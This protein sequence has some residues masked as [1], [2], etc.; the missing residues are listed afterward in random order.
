[1]VY[2]PPP[3]EENANGGKL[4]EDIFFVNVSSNDVR[5]CY[6]I[7]GSDT[8]R[9]F[10]RSQGT[11]W[12][13]VAIFE[14]GVASYF[15]ARAPP[16]PKPVS[17]DLVDEQGTQ[18]LDYYMK[19]GSHLFA[20]LQGDT[21]APLLLK[22]ALSDTS[23]SSMAVLRAILALS[24][25]HLHRTA[26]ALAY[27]ASAISLLSTSIKA[28]SET[29]VAF[30]TS[31]A[32]MLL[33]MFEVYHVS[34]TSL[35]WAVYLC[36]VKKIILDALTQRVV[37]DREC[38]TLRDW[39]YFY[40]VLSRFSILHW[41]V[42]PGRPR[43]CYER[44]KSELIRIAPDESLMEDICAVGYSRQVFDCILTITAILGPSEVPYL[45]PL[46][47]RREINEIERRLRCF[48]QDISRQDQEFPNETPDKAITIVQL[49]LLA[50]L[51]YLNR[52]AIQ[53]SG[54][55]LQHRRLVDEAL[56]HL[57]QVQ[58]RDAPWPFFII[59]S[60]ARTDSQ[61]RKV[62]QLSSMSQSDKQSDNTV[63]IQRMVEASWNQDDL[64]E[65]QS[66]S[67]TNKISA[68]ISASPFLPVFA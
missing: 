59:G 29:K 42:K 61:R 37:Y 8:G 38:I 34:D 39:I 53:Y 40:E 24:C 54:D 47:Q 20:S 68:V 26:E 66:L 56:S 23:T 11:P 46:E 19:S 9:G 21:L 28:G 62:L 27:K 31:A 64:D 25:L 55:E 17:W 48:K 7:S 67:Y 4:Y 30:Q 3:I 33:C 50:A 36:G 15:G 2:M 60:E 22:I 51:L 63:W 57:T 13:G 43:F 65:E 10:S 12:T 52:T 14:D 58:V 16:M 44:P 41:I 5:L 49:Y 6:E 32:S 1:M 18:F 45:T 35:N